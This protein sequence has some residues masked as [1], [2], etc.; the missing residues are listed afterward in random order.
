MVPLPP[1]AD[2]P[3]GVDADSWASACAAVR[4]YCGWHV[5]PSHTETVTVDGSGS[6]VQMLPTLHL[7]ELKSITNDG[8][9]VTDPEW[10]SAGMVRGSWTSKFRGVEAEMVHGFETCPA[11]VLGV[12]KGMIAAASL[13]GVS[14]VTNGSHSVQYDVSSMTSN[15][16]AILDAYRI[17]LRP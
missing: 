4:A 7:T 12:V 15:Q 5:A 9:P 1:L 10:S 14:Q 13:Q 2:A 8:R 11:E 17:P 3:A 16:L 6:S